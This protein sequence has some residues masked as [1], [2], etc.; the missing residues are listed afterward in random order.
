MESSGH[1]MGTDLGNKGRGRQI[2]LIKSLGNGKGM[3]TVVMDYN[4]K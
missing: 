2:V 4:N 1:A 3:T